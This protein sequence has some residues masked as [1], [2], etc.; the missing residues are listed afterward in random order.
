MEQLGV[1][2]KYSISAVY[3]IST[4]FYTNNTYIY[5][6]QILKI[7]TIQKALQAAQ[8]TIEMFQRKP[9]NP[10]ES[11]QWLYYRKRS[12]FGILITICITT[13]VQVPWLN[14]C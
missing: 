13:A 4:A 7:F 1:A 3:Q 12:A 6:L 2:K 11:S 10:Y 14:Y 8:T 5:I 9:H